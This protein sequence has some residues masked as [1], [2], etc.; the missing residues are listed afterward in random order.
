[1]SRTLTEEQDVCALSDDEV[2]LI[3]WLRGMELSFDDL[4]D[5]LARAVVDVSASEVAVDHPDVSAL[6]AFRHELGKIL[7]AAMDYRGGVITHIQTTH[8]R[9][10][11]W[12]F[13]ISAVVD[14]QAAQAELTLRHPEWW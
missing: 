1:M 10:D 6:H 3:K 2:K 14:G 9:R 12:V 8:K 7:E 4:R 11:V 13:E 5:H